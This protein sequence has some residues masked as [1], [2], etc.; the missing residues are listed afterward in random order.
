MN[1]AVIVTI[2]LILFGILRGWYKGFVGA[3]HTVIALVLAAGG[4]AIMMFLLDSALSKEFGDAVIA[5]IFLLL[6]LLL[7]QVIKLALGVV[8]LLS[9][10]PIVHGLDKFLGTLIGIAEGFLIVWALF[11]FLGRYNI[12][13]YNERIIHMLKENGFTAF[14]YRYNLLEYIYHYF[15]G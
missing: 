7:V 15:L 1:V 4:I 13:G 6:F 14:L 3:L 2:G 8:K 12:F 11:I 5:T 10:L 9:K